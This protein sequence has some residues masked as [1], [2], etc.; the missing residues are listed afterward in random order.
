M[1]LSVLKTSKLNYQEACEFFD[2]KENEIKFQQKI[3]EFE[4]ALIQSVKEDNEE[5]RKSWNKWDVIH[6]G[7]ILALTGAFYW[8]FW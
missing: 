2:Y 3:T 5:D 1:A 4:Q 7:I 6:S 8:Y